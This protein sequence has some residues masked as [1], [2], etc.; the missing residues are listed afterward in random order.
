MDPDGSSLHVLAV[1]EGSAVQETAYYYIKCEGTNPLQEEIGLS[2]TS[3][4]CHDILIIVADDAYASVSLME[5]AVHV[6]YD[7]GGAC[8]GNADL[9]AVLNSTEV[10][11]TRLLSPHRLLPPHFSRRKCTL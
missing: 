5:Q 8:E 2:L 9:Q 4:P 7:S 3:C 11:G 10:G 6:L 1:D